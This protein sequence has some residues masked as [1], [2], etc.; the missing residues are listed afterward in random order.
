M[1]FFV[2][3]VRIVRPM[4]RYESCVSWR[5]LASFFSDTRIFWRLYSVE[6]ALIAGI[7]SVALQLHLS[8]PEHRVR[9][10]SQ[11]G[12]AQLHPLKPIRMQLVRL[13]VELCPLS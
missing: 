11:G 12:G 9:I 1:S 5:Y 2:I 13:R 4:I 6:L 10:V 7:G 8:E 3:H